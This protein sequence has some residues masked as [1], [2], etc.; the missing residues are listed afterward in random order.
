MD[1]GIARGPRRAR[2]VAANA[3]TARADMGS[4]QAEAPNQP[5]TTPN[6]QVQAAPQAAGRRITPTHQTPEDAEEDNEPARPPPHP[7]RLHRCEL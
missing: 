5:A 4:G 7:F 2:Y 1:T 6:L 3:P